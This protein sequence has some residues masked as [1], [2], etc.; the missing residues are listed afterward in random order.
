MKAEDQY[1]VGIVVDDFDA[2]LEALTRTAG[3]RWGQ[4]LAADTNVRTP[5]GES[6]VAIRAVYSVTTPR[7]EVIQAVPGTAWTPS[8]SGAHHIGYWSSD[9]AADLAHLAS[10]GYVEESAGLGPD[11]V[12]VIWAYLRGPLGLRVELI[13]QALEPML[14]SRGAANPHLPI[15]YAHIHDEVLP[16][17]REHGV[18]GKQIS[19][20]LTANPAALFEKTN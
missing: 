12:S 14:A 7:V 16:Y 18:T 2:A 4:I 13:D 1:H 6:I 9:I 19:T 3:Y 15:S 17:A 8:N 20:M 11:G 10:Q 5:D